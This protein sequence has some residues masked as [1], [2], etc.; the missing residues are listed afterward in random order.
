VSLLGQVALEDVVAEGVGVHPPGYL[1]ENAPGVLRI[2]IG[3]V[4]A[5]HI[6]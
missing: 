4:M 2:N 3:H 5:I 1:V 6:E